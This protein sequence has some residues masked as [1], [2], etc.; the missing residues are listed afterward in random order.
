LEIF[1][2]K[3]R[4][5]RGFSP[6]SMLDEDTCAAHGL[7]ILPD[8]GDASKIACIITIGAQY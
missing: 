4:I 8:E 5:R 7:G 1:S 2:C 3:I 6:V